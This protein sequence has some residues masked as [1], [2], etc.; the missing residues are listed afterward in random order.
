MLLN[1]FFMFILLQIFVYGIHIYPYYFAYK[2]NITVS[3][4]IHELKEIDYK[5][6]I[7]S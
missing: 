6:I 2:D 5:E 3:K 4:F 1:L 7:I